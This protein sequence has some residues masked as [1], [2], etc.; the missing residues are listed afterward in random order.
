MDFLRDALRGVVEEI[1]RA[2]D[3]HGAR[4]QMFEQWMAGRVIAE[5]LALKV[6]DL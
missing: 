3:N 4:V 6:A 2:S 5:A 1:I